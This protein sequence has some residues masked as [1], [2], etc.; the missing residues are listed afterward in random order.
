MGRQC[1]DAGA[2]VDTIAI[3]IGVMPGALAHGTHAGHDARRD[4]RFNSHLTAIVKHAHR[5]AVLNAPFF[6]IERIKPDL[7]AAGRF[8]HVNVT[9]ARVGTG[10][11]MEAKQLQRILRAR[12]HPN[13]QMLRHR[14]EEG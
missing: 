5:I 11:E 12:G 9:V 1:V 7:L 14:R 3:H 10:F 4:F 8:Q 6:G 2:V 13:R